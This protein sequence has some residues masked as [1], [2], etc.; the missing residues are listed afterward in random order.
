MYIHLYNFTKK[1]FSLVRKLNYFYLEK[2]IRKMSSTVRAVI[3]NKRVA[4]G[5]PWKNGFIQ[6]Y[7]EQKSFASE[8][9][10]RSQVYQSILNGMQ[11]QSGDDS[12]SE[13]ESNKIVREAPVK[14]EVVEKFNKK[15]WIHSNLKKTTLPPGTYYIGDLCYALDDYLYENVF[16][17]SYQ[18]GYFVSSKNPNHVFMMGSTGGDGKFRGTDGK[19]YSVD[20]GI[21]GIASEGTLDP[22][23]APYKGGSLYTFKTDVTVKLREDKFIF[24]GQSSSDPSLTIYI[25][26]D[27][28]CDS[29]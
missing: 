11:F 24:Y 20:A 12:E 19:N 23:N 13:S 27:E 14:R 3:N 28:D 18:D 25:Y 5:K 6:V 2:I 1:S 21:I 7:P 29:E 8:A 9:E 16:G 22:K 4:T 17:P 26:E 10:W 15:D